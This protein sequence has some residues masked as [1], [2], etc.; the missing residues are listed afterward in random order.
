MIEANPTQ[1][2]EL[3]TLIMMPNHNMKVKPEKITTLNF[4]PTKIIRDK[5]EKKR[6]DLK[7]VDLKRKR[8]KFI[9]K[10][11]QNQI[12]RDEIEKQFQSRK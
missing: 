10:I 4:S 7:K 11:K 1:P 6:S 3:V 8:T 9:T 2:S 12:I 5:L